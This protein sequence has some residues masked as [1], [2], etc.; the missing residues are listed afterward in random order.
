MMYTMT[1]RTPNEKQIEELNSIASS[2]WRH[3]FAIMTVVPPDDDPTPTF[4]IQKSGKGEAYGLDYNAEN[5][6]DYMELMRDKI[7]ES[8]PDVRFAALLCAI[9]MYP[10]NGNSGTAEKKEGVMVHIETNDGCVATIS[11]TINRSKD[12]APTLNQPTI[13]ILDGTAE[14]KGGMIGF[15]RKNCGTEQMH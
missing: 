2:M 12:R 1:P 10:A 9:Y 3:V 8:G 7:A 6:H 15:F 5:K 4:F 14:I 13:S 11:A